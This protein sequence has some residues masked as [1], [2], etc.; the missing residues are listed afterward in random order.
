MGQKFGTQPT[1]GEW[2]AGSP[3]NTKSPGPRPISIPCDI[4]IHPA[5]WLHQI[6]AEYWGLCLLGG[7]LAGSPSNSVA[8]TKAY[9]HAKF[10]LD[11]SNRLAIVHQRHIQTDMTGQT[12]IGLIA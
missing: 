8:R 2:R 5:I 4:L 6:W 3:S 7:K 10:R 12:D 9:L 11:P 1:F